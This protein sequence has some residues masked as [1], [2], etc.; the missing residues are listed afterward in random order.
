MVDTGTLAKKTVKNV[1]WS[2]VAFASGK[3]VTFVTTVILARLL[4]PEDFGLLAMALLA[5]N[6]LDV[7]N[8]FGV[9]AGYIYRQDEPEKTG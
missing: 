7:F 3:L 4:A 5:V 1:F 8:N 9:G 6:Y 2:Y